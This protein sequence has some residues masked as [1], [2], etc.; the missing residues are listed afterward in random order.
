MAPSANAAA[1]RCTL[2]PRRSFTSF[3]ES[4]DQSPRYW[5]SPAASGAGSLRGSASLP[6][7]RRRSR[8]GLAQPVLLRRDQ[9]P[10]D[11]GEV[12][13]QVPGEDQEQRR[14]QQVDAVRIA[15]AVQAGAGDE[16]EDGQQRGDLR[17]QR[18]AVQEGREG[19]RAFGQAFEDR[20]RRAGA[21]NGRAKPRFFL[22]R[23]ASWRA[24]AHCGWRTAGRLRKVFR[25]SCPPSR[26]HASARPCVQ[27]ARSWFSCL[28]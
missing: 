27:S 12:D 15:D 4:C 23:P 25:V 21:G 10:D 24:R 28:F 7:A 16:A 18:T 1:A 2:R 8:P 26:W 11:E 17:H 19:G 9:G 22:R 14:R 20:G 6:T 3:A 13:Q 5:V